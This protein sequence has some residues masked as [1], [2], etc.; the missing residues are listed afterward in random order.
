[1]STW[2]Y[3]QCESHEP[4]LIA[5]DESGQHLYDLP[6]LRKDVAEREALV[7][8]MDDGWS[9]DDYYRRHTVKFLA[10]H[11]KCQ[12]GIIDEYNRTYPLLE[13]NDGEDM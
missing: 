13:E 1:M 9:I 4:P 6:Q 10:A 2:I 7:K 8:M 12:L 11:R 3:L 5:E